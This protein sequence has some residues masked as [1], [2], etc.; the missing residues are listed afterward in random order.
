MLIDYLGAA[1]L[2]QCLQLAS[3]RAKIHNHQYE[4]ENREPK[5]SQ[6]F[7][8]TFVRFR[9][10]ETTPIIEGL[11]LLFEENAQKSI[12][13]ELNTPTNNARTG[14]GIV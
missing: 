7:N 10:D 8:N 6:Q 2:I 11:F 14:C 9:P 3:L 13:V 1:S 5:Q 12:G 4:R